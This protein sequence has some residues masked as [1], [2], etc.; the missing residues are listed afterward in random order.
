MGKQQSMGPFPFHSLQAI[1]DVSVGRPLP[2][3]RDHGLPEP[4]LHTVLLQH[5]QAP[6]HL[7]RPLG[8]HRPHLRRPILGQVRDQSEEVIPVR[9]GV[10]FAP[11][12]VEEASRLP[13]QGESPPEIAESLFEL[14]PQERVFQYRLSEGLPLFGKTEG[15]RHGSLG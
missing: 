2:D 15:I 12:L 4:P 14:R 1:Q 11:Y 9:V 5:A 13:G 7:H 3:G 10:T 8:R 6:V